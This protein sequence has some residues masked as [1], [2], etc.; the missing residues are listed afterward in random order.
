MSQKWYLD[1]LAFVGFLHQNLL[2]KSIVGE[3]RMIAAPLLPEISQFMFR[4]LAY[5]WMFSPDLFLH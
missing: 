4:F 2:Q 1:D 5:L 3:L